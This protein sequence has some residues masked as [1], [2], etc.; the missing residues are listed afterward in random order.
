[1]KLLGISGLA[2][3]GKDTVANF[4][5]NLN[6]VP[7]ALADP[8]KRICREV[9]DFTEDQLWGPSASR[10]KPDTRYLRKHG[11]WTT[12]SKCACCGMPGKLD[13]FE[14]GGPCHLTPRFALQMLGT[15]WG[16]ACFDNTWV[17]LAIQNA[18]KLLGPNLV[19]YNQMT[20]FYSL[21]TALEIPTFGQG[22]AISDVRFKNEMTA[23]KEAGGKLIRVVRPGAGLKGATGLHASEVEQMSI[24]NEN[25]DVV[26]VND[27]TL[28]D[29]ARCAREAAE[30]LA[31]G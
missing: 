14:E 25:F 16:R 31:F 20:G 10:N 4:L 15:E 26:I 1:M 12:D 5:R 18:R 17:N 30:S 9:F 13:G 22:V 3:S 23:I 2:G 21:V 29:L 6:F 24:P 27:G 11:P 7:I 28:D 19:G 8:L